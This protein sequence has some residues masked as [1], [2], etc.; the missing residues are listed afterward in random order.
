MKILRCCCA[1]VL[2]L[3]VLGCEEYVLSL[4]PLCSDESCVSVPGLEGK[5]ASGGQIWTIR[6]Q[7]TA[8]YEVRV[9]DMM[10]AALFGGRT[11]HIGDH[12][13]LELKP[14]RGAEDAP[15][16]SLFAAHLLQASS[17]MQVKLEGNALSLQR[18]SAGGLKNRL[19]E[20]PGLIKHMVKDDNVILLDETEALVQF[21]Q[22]QA[23]VNELWQEQGEFVRCAPLYSAED[24]VASAGL[25][26]RWS[27]PNDGE[28][29]QMDIRTEGNQLEI[30]FTSNSERRMTFSAHVFKIRNLSLMGI[31]MGSGDMLSREMATLMPD[32]YA[33]IALKN[34]RLNLTVL[35]FMKV[36][37]LLAHPE[38]AQEIQGEPDA[39]LIRVK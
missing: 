23:D 10:S 17:F 11:R 20:Q 1:A 27:D 12:V 34:D 5:W 32:M 7:D 39:K 24:L 2:L 26:G 19:Q 21:V 13:F 18:M 30:Q 9:V 31:F 37:D 15:V 33:S 28:D 36:K 16:P 8:G 25:T 14:V 3:G 6:P 38:K 35:D 22:A 29:Y 4:K